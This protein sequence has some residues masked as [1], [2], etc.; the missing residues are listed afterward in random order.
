M[1][2]ILTWFRYIT[3]KQLQVQCKGCGSKQYITRMLL[4]MEPRKR[5]PEESRRKLAL[6][7]ALTSYR[8]AEKFGKMFGWAIDKMTIWKS[9]QQVGAGLNFA[10]DENEEARCEAD[11]TGVGITGITKRVNELKVLIKY[12]KGGGVRVAGIDI[13][14]YNGSGSVRV[15]GG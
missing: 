15:M 2:T 4:G 9:V 12:K 11:G 13:G 8:V 7:G 1:T 6:L 10:L 14:N 5:I 3:L